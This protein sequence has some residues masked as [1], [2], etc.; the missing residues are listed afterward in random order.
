MTQKEALRARQKL[1]DRL[2]VTG[3]ILRGSLIERRVFRHRA[4]CEKCASGEGHPLNVLTVT[5][6]GGRTRQFSLRAEIVPQV[7]HW[8]E[9]YKNLKEALEEICELNHHLLRREETPVM[10]ARRKT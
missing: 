5:Y 3:E 10:R 7:R 4:N 9:N 2:P 8:L 6:P 1:L